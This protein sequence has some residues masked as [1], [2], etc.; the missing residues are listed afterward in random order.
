MSN[1]A[2]FLPLS[3]LESISPTLL[4]AVDSIPDANTDKLVEPAIST[5]TN[6]E[7]ENALTD[8]ALAARVLGNLSTSL[9][10]VLDRFNTRGVKAEPASTTNPIVNIIDDITPTAPRLS[11]REQAILRLLQDNTGRIVTKSEFRRIVGNVDISPDIAR[12]RKHGHVIESTQTIRK[13][14]EPVPGNMAGYR[15]SVK[16]NAE[17][18]DSDRTKRELRNLLSTLVNSVL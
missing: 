6:V 13:N 3:E 10:V 9:E 4:D 14:G 5:E 17:R 7:L 15:L 11:V 2:I 18:R 1:D 12:I 8:L 16:H